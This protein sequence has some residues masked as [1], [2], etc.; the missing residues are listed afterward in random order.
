MGVLIPIYLF[1]P[2]YKILFGHLLAQTLDFGMIDA[3]ASVI[4]DG[5]PVKK[6]PYRIHN[7]KNV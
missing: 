6:T 5:G 3:P 2:W 7:D 4:W 1:L